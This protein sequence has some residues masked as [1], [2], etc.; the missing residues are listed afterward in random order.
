MRKSISTAIALCMTVIMGA[1]AQTTHPLPL[2]PNV[3]MGVLETD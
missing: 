1:F 2:D 3:R